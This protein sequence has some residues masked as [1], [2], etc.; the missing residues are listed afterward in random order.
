MLN[1]YDFF[2]PFLLIPAIIKTR[3]L[4]GYQVFPEVSEAAMQAQDV[5][6]IN[7]NARNKDGALDIQQNSLSI[8]S[9]RNQIY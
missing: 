3:C 6:C 2:F 1:R 4:L 8:T 9:P 5:D 7:E